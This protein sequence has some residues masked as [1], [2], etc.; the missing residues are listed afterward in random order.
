M[1]E[2]SL[3]KL[4]EKGIPVCINSDDPPMFDCKLNKEISAVANTFDFDFGTMT[5]ILRNAIEH[6]FQ[7]ESAKEALLTD[8]DAVIKDG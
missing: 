1:H 5:T 7:E 3:P 8:F 6:S 2:H 4:I